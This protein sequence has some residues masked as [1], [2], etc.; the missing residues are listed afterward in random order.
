MIRI[1]SDSTCDM[2]HEELKALDILTLPL[3]IHFEQESFRDSIDLDSESFYVKL[4]N[5]KSLPT[6]SQ[7]PPGEF[8]DLFRPLIAQGDDLVVVTLAAKL[9]ATYQS[10][11]TAAELVS[12]E[13]IHVVDSMSGSFGHVLLL[14]RAVK[15]RDEG[16][17][18]A[19]EIAQELRQ[20][21]P[22]V[23]LYAAVDTLKYLKMGG[24]LS[25]SAALIGGLLGIK[26]LLEV[27]HGEVHSIA[28]IRGERNVIKELLEHFLAAK[29]D[30]RYGVS[31]GNSVAKERMQQ[32]IEHFRPHLGDI[33]IYQT[34]LGA[35]IGTHTGPGVVGVGF[36]S[37]EE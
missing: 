12:P 4:K 33:P 1:I 30:L 7:V 5:A 19:A 2:T 10:A 11:V 13:R 15:L 28:K 23:R 32:A 24:R 8:E 37:Q 16:R 29:P 25:G 17:M 27:K 26:P 3:T 22:R 6:T 14:Q 34:D 20:L 36:I 18:S 9:S 31:F 21:A 35:V